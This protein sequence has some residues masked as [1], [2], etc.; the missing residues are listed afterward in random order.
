[1]KRYAVFATDTYY[2]GGG[3]WDLEGLYETLEEGKARARLLS[4]MSGTGWDRVP[5]FIGPQRP[6][7]RE[8]VQ[9]VDLV[10]GEEVGY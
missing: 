8:I 5:D 6:M 3:W 4:N 7:W 1:M 10:A 9:L 2:P